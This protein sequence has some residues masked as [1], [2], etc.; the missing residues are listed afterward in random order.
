MRPSL[1]LVKPCY[2]SSVVLCVSMPPIRDFSRSTRTDT[3]IKQN[4]THVTGLFTAV[5]PATLG[6]DDYHVW[7]IQRHSFRRRRPCC[8]RADLFPPH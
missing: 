1:I 3:A 6:Q 2:S 5:F 4:L 7:T 8:S